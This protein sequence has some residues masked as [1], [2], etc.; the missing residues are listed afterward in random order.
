M[1]DNDPDRDAPSPKGRP[2]CRTGISRLALTGEVCWRI[3]EMIKS[4]VD[5]QKGVL[6]G[7]YADEIV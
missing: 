6:S 3:R 7:A 2:T 1:V 4:D 5:D